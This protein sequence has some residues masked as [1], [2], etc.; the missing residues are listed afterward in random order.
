MSRE[1]LPARR[2]QLTDSS[3]RWPIDSGRR[4]HISVGLSSD[5]RCLE[6][7]ARGA[8]KTGTDLDFTLDDAAI[9]LS[10]LLQ[11]GDRLEDIARGLS[12]FPDGRPSSIVGVIVDKAREI[13]A[14]LDRVRAELPAKRPM[15]AAGNE[16][17]E[18]A[19]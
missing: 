2:S 7:F 18:P 10:R 16:T 12:R 8:S 19:S 15:A 9:M 4:L 11:H 1:R 14:D 13:E 6:V 17:P 3:A 5:G